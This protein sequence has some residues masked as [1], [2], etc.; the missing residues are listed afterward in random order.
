MRRLD[1]ESS[2][3][4]VL[5][6]QLGSKR[7]NM[8]MRLSTCCSPYCRAPITKNNVVNYKSPFTDARGVQRELGFCSTACVAAV[9]I[10]IAQG[11]ISNK[12]ID[13]ALWGTNKW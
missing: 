6:V 5:V 4:L 11:D 3:L 8:K 7:G 13:E 12:N 2:S 9:N 10:S 1:P